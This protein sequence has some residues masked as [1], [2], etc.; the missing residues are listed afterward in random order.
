MMCNLYSMTRSQEAMR[1]LF[2][3]RRELAGNLPLPPAIFPD[4]LAPIV[5]VAEG[6]RQIE[7]MRWGMPGPPQFGAAPVTNIRNVKSPHWRRWLGPESRSLVPF[8]SFC[9]YEDTGVPKAKKVPTW[10]AV[11]PRFDA[12]RRYYPLVSPVI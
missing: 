10:F 7:M 5:R 1:Q 4:Q 8:T 11:D 6:E 2:K 3:T 9:E 12:E